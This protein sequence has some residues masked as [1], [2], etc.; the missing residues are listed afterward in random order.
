MLLPDPCQLICELCRLFYSKGWVTGTGGG[1]SIKQGWVQKANIDIAVKNQHLFSK[2]NICC[3]KSTCSVKKINISSKNNICRETGIS[4]HNGWPIKGLL[5]PLNTILLWCTGV[6]S[7]PHDAD[8]RQSL[9]Q[10]YVWSLLFFQSEVQIFIR[11]L[12]SFEIKDMS[13]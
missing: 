6:F 4:R 7:G 2:I 9:G 13:G 11:R 3:Q 12:A 10:L 1:I 5:K 8:R